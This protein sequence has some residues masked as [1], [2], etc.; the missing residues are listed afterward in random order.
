MQEKLKQAIIEAQRNEITEHAVYQRLAR[1][2]KDPENR[3][4]LERIA[5]DERRHYDFW[6][7][8]SNERPPPRKHVAWAYIW[9]ARLFGLTFAVRLMERREES[10]QV[11]YSDMA[12]AIP[13][14]AEIARDEEEHERELTAL[15]DEER[16]RYVGSMVL[17]LSDAL[18][19]LTGALAGLTLAIQKGRLIAAIG[20]ITGIAAAMS[21]AA[22]EY[23]STKSDEDHQRNPVKAA[24]YTGSAYLLTVVLLILPYLLLGNALAALGCTVATAL[25]II[26]V[27]TYYISVARDLPL[28]PR[29]LEMAALS[30]GVAAISFGIGYL[31]RIAFGVEAA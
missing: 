22:S 23:L 26:L 25:L 15:I 19:E 20:L 6:A 5:R 16:L 8:Q 18:V 2:Q 10:A 31:I 3:S 9:I 1:I 13:G 21:M 24:L 30:L 29:F 17:G 27:F 11:N 28:W 4:V 12:K 7:E 14:A